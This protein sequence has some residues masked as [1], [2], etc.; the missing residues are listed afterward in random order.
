MQQS[1]KY[2]TG[3]LVWALN[4][5]RKHTWVK[6]TKIVYPKMWPTHN[7][8]IS[9]VQEEEEWT[10]SVLTPHKN[11]PHW[12]D[13]SEPSALLFLH[14]HSTAE[15]YLLSNAE[16]HAM[17]HICLCLNSHKSQPETSCELTWPVY[18]VNPHVCDVPVCLYLRQLGEAI[19]STEGGLQM[20][21]CE[22]ASVQTWRL[23]HWHHSPPEPDASHTPAVNRH[24]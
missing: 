17:Q 13:Q 24:K 1:R 8:N 18:Q 2:N 14:R 10:A 16:L 15:N 9:L 20:Q 4:K 7:R 22:W 5:E 23:R 21:Q 12:W 6:T 3:I 11:D 19:T